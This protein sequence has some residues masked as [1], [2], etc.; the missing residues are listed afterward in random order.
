M[1]QNDLDFFVIGGGSGGGGS[2]V[3]RSAAGVGSSRPQNQDHRSAGVVVVGDPLSDD[4]PRERARRV[5]RAMNGAN[6]V[7]VEGVRYG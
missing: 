7:A 2:S 5:R 6:R 3:A 1:Q 4:S